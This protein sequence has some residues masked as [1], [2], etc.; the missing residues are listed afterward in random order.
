MVVLRVDQA[1]SGQMICESAKT[2]TRSSPT[3][4][5][6]DRHCQR[7]GCGLGTEPEGQ[8]KRASRVAR[9][10]IGGPKGGKARA[11]KLAPEQR[12]NI[13]RLAAQ[14]RW[15]NRGRKA[16]IRQKAAFQFNPGYRKSRGRKVDSDFRRYGRAHQFTSKATTQSARSC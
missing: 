7:R 8:G 1:A 12:A 10:K 14:T 3:R 6:H 2:P 5:T 16:D 11:L 4:Q 15:K 13:A 9:G